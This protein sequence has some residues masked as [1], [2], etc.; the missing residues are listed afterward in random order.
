MSDHEPAHLTAPLREAALAAGW[1]QTRTPP[2]TPLPPGTVL[3]GVWSAPDDAAQLAVGEPDPDL[4]PDPDQRCV[5]VVLTGDQAPHRPWTITGHCPVVI[6]PDVVTAAS[7]PP[8]TT[9]P[10][11]PSLLP[12]GAYFREV[13]P[14][15]PRGRYYEERWLDWGWGAD[16]MPLLAELVFFLPGSA[17]AP[18]TYGGWY[19]VTAGPND[20]TL[21]A[22]LATPRHIVAAL[23]AAVARRSYEN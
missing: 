11:P 9:A 2:P 21:H 3:L 13:D 16:Y 14:G 5:S 19:L 6:L 22:D 10:D 1:L 15:Y 7:F 8:G 18:H 20:T 4:C 17:S 12:P 23:V